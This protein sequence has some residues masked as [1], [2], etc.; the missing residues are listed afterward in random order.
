MAE[1]RL[2]FDD[3]DADAV[4]DVCMRCGGPAVVRPVK[5]FGWVP[6]SARFLPVLM[7]LAFLKRRRTPVPLCEK[8]K[9]YWMFRVIVALGGV[10]L[11]VP[12]LLCRGGLIGG[13]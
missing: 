10:G 7:R 3:L 12:A 5:D 8:H 6:P 1:V 11:L 13:N 4:P 9:H 2:H